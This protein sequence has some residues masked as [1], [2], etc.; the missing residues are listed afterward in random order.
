MLMNTW[1]TSEHNWGLSYEASSTLWK[2][3]R[4]SYENTWFVETYH[5]NDRRQSL[6][7]IYR[8]L[9]N[10]PKIYEK[11]QNSAHFDYSLEK[12]KPNL[13]FINTQFFV[14]KQTKSKIQ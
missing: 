7:K 6:V 11:P 8:N 9:N 2:R 14:G 12:Y 3:Y 13:E 1:N 5:N 10:A 4:I